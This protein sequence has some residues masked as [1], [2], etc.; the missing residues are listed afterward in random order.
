MATRRRSVNTLAGRSFKFEGMAELQ[1]QLGKII[2]GVTGE[3]MKQ[4]FLSQAI[5]LRDEAKRIAPLGETGNLRRGIFAS[6][7][8]E[9]KPNAIVGVDYRVAP[10]SH[11]VEFGHA[12]PHPAP[13]H[14]FM[15]PAILNKT[16]AVRKGMADGLGAII[17]KYS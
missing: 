6:R 3:E 4:V 14:P 2:D 16:E 8:D 11:L 7:G 17:K 10:H 13:P 5:V 12:G 15:R 9:N 1:E